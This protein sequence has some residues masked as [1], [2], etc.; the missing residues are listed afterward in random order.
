MALITPDFTDAA[1]FDAI[2]EGVYKTR[3]TKG[4]VKISQKGDQYVNWTLS[5][6]DSA[7]GKNLN[8]N[9]WHTTMCSGRGAGL[10]KKFLKEVTG[11]VP[12]QF[13]TE[14]LIGRQIEVTVGHRIDDKGEKR[15]EVKA[16]R[17]L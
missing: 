1:E 11:E 15:A 10:L 9:I 6:F 7:D 4:E 14:A 16:V 2:P 13:D 12:P 17:A 5:V 8:R 3:I